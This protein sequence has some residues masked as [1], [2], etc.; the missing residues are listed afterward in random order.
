MD[1]WLLVRLPFRPLGPEITRH[2]RQSN[3]YAIGST[4]GLG[5]RR[6]RGIRHPGCA[7][8]GAQGPL[9]ASTDPDERPH[10]LVDYRH[11]ALKE[12]V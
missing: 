1:S 7:N 10:P 5:Y 3:G 2:L 11:E 6:G 8:R 12:L 4:E 9:K